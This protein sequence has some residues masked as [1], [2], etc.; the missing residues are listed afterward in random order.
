MIAV[1][2]TDDNWAIGRSGDLLFHIKE[3][4]KEFK[5]MTINGIVVMGRKTWESLPIKPLPNRVNLIVTSEDKKNDPEND[6]YYC[7]IEDVMSTI[8][9]LQ[10][11]Y[12]ISDYKTFLIGG[13]Q[14]YKTLINKCSTAVIT[15]V[16]TI[17]PDA[18]TYFPNLDKSHS[19]VTRLY[20][21]Q[22][23]VSPELDGILFDT[24]RYY[25]ISEAE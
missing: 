22:S 10:S 7:K 8:K 11:D 20:R 19:W 16:H 3:D 24:V 1:V 12:D 14:L 18:D 5:K 9:F 4:M 21:D 23:K 2:C 13:G 17:V 6:I 25:N 15:R